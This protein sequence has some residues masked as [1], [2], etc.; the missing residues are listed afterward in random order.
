MT[1]KRRF[2]EGQPEPLALIGADLVVTR[3]R[4]KKL[5]D[6]QGVVWGLYGLAKRTS[7][8]DIVL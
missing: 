3:V 1:A 7:T 4:H 8:V 6:V 2:G 5:P